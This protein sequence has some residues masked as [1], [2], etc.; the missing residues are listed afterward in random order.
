MALALCVL[1]DRPRPSARHRAHARTGCTHINSV[2]THRGPSPLVGVSY[3]TH[4]NYYF[5]SSNKHFL[6]GDIMVC[7]CCVSLPRVSLVLG[8]TALGM[9]G[10]SRLLLRKRSV[11]GSVSQ[12]FAICLLLFSGVLVALDNHAGL[13]K[14]AF[15]R[16]CQT[17]ASLDDLNKLRCDSLGIREVGGDVIEFGPGPGTNFRC[18]GKEDVRHTGRLR[19]WVGVDPNEDFE[20]MQEA[21]AVRRN[22]TYF[23]RETVWLRG[24]DVAVEAGTFDAAVLTHVLCSVSDPAAIL[25]QAAR[26]LRPGGKI[27]ILE[28]VAADEGTALWYVQ[29]L[30]APVFYIVANG[31]TFRNAVAVLRA[32]TSGFEPFAIEALDAPISIP[33]MRP[34]IIATAVKKAWRR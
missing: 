27:Y 30:A 3:T 14:F 19:R 21:E 13:R 12:A 20:A 18:W 33:I 31:C 34:H 22:A 4:T 28:H 16:L 9:I 32:D 23:P 5:K 11:S 2:Y 26:A 7:A 10:G 15:A 29:Q 25:R 17:V 6:G 1:C 8:T 24:E